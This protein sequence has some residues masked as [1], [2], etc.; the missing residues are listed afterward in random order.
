MK[1]SGLAKTLG[2]LALGAMPFVSP[3]AASLSFSADV[4]LGLTY[5]QSFVSKVKDIPLSVRNVPVHPDDYGNSGPIQKDELNPADRVSLFELKLG[6]KLTFF[7]RRAFLRAGAG[8]DLNFSS[9]ALEFWKE[10][11][12]R[13]D[14][15]ERNYLNNPGSDQRGEG[16]ALT[17][18]YAGTRYTPTWNTFFKPYVFA[19]AGFNITKHLSVRAG[20]KLFQE[21]IF[22]ENGW[23]RYNSLE[24]RDTFPLVDYTVLQPFV[25]LNLKR[26]NY[27]SDK[28]RGYASLDVGFLYPLSESKTKMG[29]QVTLNKNE[30]AVFVG[31]KAG[32]DY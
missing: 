25:S 7:D 31:I 6:P 13:A 11:N 32:F 10:P 24:T 20:A 3:K 12:D 21:Q 27:S 5:E 23:D 9:Q 15:A 14:I 29:R 17:Y 22:L 1:T 26:D 16:A 30:P 19:D 28:V 8:L 4:N 2:I 18:I